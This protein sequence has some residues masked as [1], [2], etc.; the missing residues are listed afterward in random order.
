[1]FENLT[2]IHAFQKGEITRKE[3]RSL[4]KKGICS[5]CRDPSVLKIYSDTPSVLLIEPTPDWDLK[6]YADDHKSE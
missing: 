4:R 2:Q 5:S 3:M 6:E 1:M